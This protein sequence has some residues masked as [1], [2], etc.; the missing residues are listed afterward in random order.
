MFSEQC[1]RDMCV[2]SAL[3][4]QPLN[5]SV[6]LFGDVLQLIVMCEAVSVHVKHN[7]LIKIFYKY[8]KTC[9]YSM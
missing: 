5:T 2:Q 9:K 4:L 1:I 3:L 8:H 6:N 7:T